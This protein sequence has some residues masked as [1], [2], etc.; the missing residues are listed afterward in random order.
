VLGLQTAELKELQKK[1]ETSKNNATR[2]REENEVLLKQNQSLVQ[3]IANN[4][5]DPL[6]RRQAEIANNATLN[7][8][9]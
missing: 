3:D 7:D 8:S 2:L 5:Q 4:I 9:K 1:T 6:K